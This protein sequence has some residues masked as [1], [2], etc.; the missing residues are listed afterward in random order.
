M[1]TCKKKTKTPPPE[2]SAEQAGVAK[3]GQP[4]GP[5]EIMIIY[6]EARAKDLVSAFL[7][8]KKMSVAT[9]MGVKLIDGTVITGILDMEVMPGGTIVIIKINTMKGQEYRA[10]KTETIDALINV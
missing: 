8:L 1:S 10:I 3:L 5:S 7:Y 4:Q 6:P 2:T 9:Q